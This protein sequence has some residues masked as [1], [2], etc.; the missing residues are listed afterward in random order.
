[1]A[2]ENEKNEQ[3]GSSVLKKFA[4]VDALAHAYEALE[5][6][7]TRRSQRLKELE[8]RNKEAAAPDMGQPEAPSER[9]DC[10][11]ETL[12]RKAVENDAVRA[13]ILSDYLSSLKGVP[14]M[15]GEGVG[16][17]AP[18]RKPK[19]IAEAGNFALDYFKSK[20]KEL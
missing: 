13:R 2:E 9:A 8:Q 6:E 10:E 5:A 17:A 4:S 19:S 12:Y 7:F 16:V 11:S 14:L 3:E 20:N 1:M 15:T 18:A